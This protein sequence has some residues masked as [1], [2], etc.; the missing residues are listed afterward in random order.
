[1]VDFPTRMKARRRGNRGT[2]RAGCPEKRVGERQL[3][4]RAEVRANNR[5][6]R[7][8]DA[9]REEVSGKLRDLVRLFVEREMA[10]IKGMDLGVWNIACVRQRARY[11]EGRIIASPGMWRSG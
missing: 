8:P 5:S 6:A 9:A 7:R 3:G 11:D 4:S 1:M 10:G 2:W